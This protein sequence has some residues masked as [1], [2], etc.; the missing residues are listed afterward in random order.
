MIRHNSILRDF[1]DADWTDRAEMEKQLSYSMELFSN[2]NMTEGQSPF[3]TSVCLF[4]KKDQY[5]R[6][7]YYPMTVSAGRIGNRVSGNDAG[8]SPNRR[9]VSDDVRG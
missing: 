3:V 7:H 5:V 6:E 8:L 2:R 1:F 9:T 4:N